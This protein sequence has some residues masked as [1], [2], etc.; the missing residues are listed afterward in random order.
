[1]C[2]DF[3]GATPELRAAVPFP[4]ILARVLLSQRDQYRL[5]PRPANS[6]PN[7]PARSGTTPPRAPP[8]PWSAIGSPPAW[9]RRTR[10]SW[11]PSCRARTLFARRAAGR[12]EDQQ[13]IA[14]N[15]DLVF[16]VC[17]LDGDFNLRRLERYLTLAAESGASPGGRTQQERSLR[18][19]RR[20]A[21]GDR[22]GRRRRPHRHR[23]HTQRRAARAAARASRAGTHGRAAGLL[24][25]RQIVDRQLPR[26]RRSPANRR[27]TRVRQ[28]RTPHHHAPR[29]H[30]RCPRVA[31]SSILPACA[32]CNS[33]PARTRSTRSSTRS[34]R[35]PPPAASAIAAT[36]PKWAAPCSGARRRHAGRGALAELPEAPHR[37]PP[38]RIDGRPLARARSRSANCA[39]CIKA[40]KEIYKAPKYRG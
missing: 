18:R 8:C 31:R 5:I 24:R 22:G 38:P 21:G 32:S 28:P 1:M 37:S 14:A 25:R 16:L 13:P 27:G 20:A 17:G 12:R 4:L 33:G 26:R 29:T 36:Q 30:R 23:Q 40:V 35:S 6:T 34:L 11:R 10:R 2:L 7:P 3:L 15:I 9:S 39:A 19:S